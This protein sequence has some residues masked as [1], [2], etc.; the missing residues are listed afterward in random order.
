MQ[1]FIHFRYKCVFLSY[2]PCYDDVL[3]AE[4]NAKSRRAVQYTKGAKYLE[5]SHSV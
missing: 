3:A 4:T 5:S 2:Y 1:A